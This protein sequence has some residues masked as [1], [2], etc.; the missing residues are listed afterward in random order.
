MSLDRLVSYL[1][2]HPTQ[3]NDTK[4]IQW[5]YTMKKIIII[6]ITTRI[7]LSFAFVYKTRRFKDYVTFTS[8]GKA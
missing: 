7:T 3:E 6:Y 8:T 5:E 1:P 4:K 2:I